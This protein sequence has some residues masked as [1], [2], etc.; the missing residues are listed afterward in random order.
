MT[1]AFHA[2]SHGDFR[3]AVELN[4]LS[5]ILF[6]AFLLVLVL[7]VIQLTTGFRPSIK[8]PRRVTAWGGYAA[9]VVVLA[10][11]VVRN[12]VDIP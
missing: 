6:F 3:E 7:D 4:L 10:Y 12:I 1:R 8:L 9:L 2:L 5:P 11:G